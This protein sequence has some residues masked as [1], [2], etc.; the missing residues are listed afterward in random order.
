[1]DDPSKGLYDDCVQV[2]YDD[3]DD[4]DDDNDDD[5][6]LYDDCVQVLSLWVTNPYCSCATKI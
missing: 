5:E 4:D 1:M 3:G 2:L 6:S